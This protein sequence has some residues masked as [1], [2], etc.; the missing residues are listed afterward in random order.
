VVAR[1]GRTQLRHVDD[2]MDVSKL[3]AN[4]MHVERV[5]TDL[6]RLSRFVASHFEVLATEKRVAYTLEIPEGIHAVVDPDKVRRV[7]LNLLSN[8]FKFTPG[9]G[10]VRLG[11]RAAGRRVTIEVADSGPGIPE[12]MREA[13]F[14]R[15]RQLNRGPGRRYGGTGLGLSIVHDFV[16]FHGGT[17]SVT[18]APEGGSLFVFDFPIVA[19]AGGA[20][21][22][23]AAEAT[24][25]QEAEARQAAEDLRGA[26]SPPPPPEGATSGA[27]I[28]VVEDNPEM[29]RFICESL[30]PDHRVAPAFSGEEGLQRAIELGPDL[31]VADIMMPGMGGDELVRAIRARDELDR[32]PIV[33]L[34]ARADDDLRLRLLREGAQDYLTKPFAVEELRTR[35]DNLVSA[36]RIEQAL[37]R[38]E[39]MSSGILSVSA[40]ALIS[41][42]EDQ[43][44]TMFNEGAERMFGYTKAE[45][46]GSLLDVLIPERHRAAHRL[47]VERFAMGREVA[48]R[49]GE[50][51]AAIVGL[52]KDGEEFSA[53]A[54]IPSAT[55]RTPSSAS[56][57]T[58]ASWRPRQ[59]AGGC[60]D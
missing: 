29:N 13:V 56:W 27:L 5:D 54:T 41:I 43:R 30:A 47:H 22:G 32:T 26:P 44:I 58:S 8:A 42:D 57:R 12:D 17:T 39:A 9:G 2:L 48:R 34:T 7:L 33:P 35:I 21:P 31:I 25:V 45:A 53:D 23:I 1:N 46:I 10:R 4:R 50:R 14:E 60:T 20:V 3:E 59:K 6:S 40:D 36:R 15:F 28:L 51:R 11:L 52:R 24:L 16:P 49:M 55:W 38:S 37:R 19:P 18:Q